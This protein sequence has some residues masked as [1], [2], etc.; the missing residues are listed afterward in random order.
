MVS[1]YKWVAEISGEEQ[2]GKGEM[3]K[4]K[5]SKT[6]VPRWKDLVRGGGKSGECEVSGREKPPYGWVGKHPMGSLVHSLFLI[7]SSWL[8]PI[9]CWH[10]TEKF[11]ELLLVSEMQVLASHMTASCSLMCKWSYPWPP[12]GSTSARAAVVWLGQ[13]DLWSGHWQAEQV[14]ATISSASKCVYSGW[15]LLVLCLLC[16]AVIYCTFYDL[17]WFL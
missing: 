10:L 13:P 12:D 11:L 15:L 9:G 6:E 2:H 3:R 1:W 5:G 4:D 14:H 16:W 17:P 8:G 7:Q